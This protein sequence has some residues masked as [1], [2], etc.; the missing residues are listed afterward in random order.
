MAEKRSRYQ[1]LERVMTVLLITVAV[2]FV[3]F[4]IF[5]G[6]GIVWA[7]VLTAIFAMLMTV[8]CL[9][10]LYMTRELLRQRSLWLTT[11]FGAAFVCTLMSLICNFPRA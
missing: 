2:D 5:A 1:D 7:K 8:L 10:Y 9:G 11:G 6:S 3:L 4:L